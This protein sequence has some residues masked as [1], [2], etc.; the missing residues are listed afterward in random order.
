MKDVS[1]RKIQVIDLSIGNISSIRNM[2]LKIGCEVGV[3]SKP[4]ENSHDSLLI[5]A[6][7]GAFDSGVT[8]LQ[9]SGWFDEIKS[10]AVNGQ[11]ILGICLGMQLLCAGSAEGG[12]SGLNLIPG[13]FSHLRDAREGIDLKVPHMGWNHVTVNDGTKHL[14]QLIGEDALR[15]Y[16]VHSFEYQHSTSE[17][18]IGNANY[19]GN[20]VA[21][22]EKNNVMGVQFHPEKSHRYGMKFL[23]AYLES[24][25]A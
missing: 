8:H 24:I 6:G 21:M 4:E 14:K 3:I 5:L 19:K 20:V 17:F 22:I 12:L 7:V 1:M 13:H 23:S 18:V 11:H 16:F 25:S 2:F 10:A 15:F 9:N